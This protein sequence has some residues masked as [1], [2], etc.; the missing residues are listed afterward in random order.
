[1]GQSEI[2]KSYGRCCANAGFLDR[3]YEIFLS[4][5]PSIPALFAH[6]DFA[7]QKALLRSGIA[8]VVMH[9]QGDVFGTRALNKIA[10]S[11]SKSNLDI[12]PCFY[13]L[14]IDSLMQAIKECD[15]ELTP[16]LESAWRRVLEAGALYIT[17]RHNA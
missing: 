13:P 1:M 5:H 10:E 8:M 12:N 6:T 4:S 11:H 2:D 9:A 3:F 7:K 15:P 16:A 14:W 17:S